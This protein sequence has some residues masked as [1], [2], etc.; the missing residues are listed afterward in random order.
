L[1]VYSRSGKR[2]VSYR[3]SAAWTWVSPPAEAVLGHVRDGLQERERHV[4]PDDGGGL[5]EALVLGRQPVD[6]RRE[7]CLRR[8]RDL[9]R[10]RRLR[11]PIGPPLSDEHLGFHEGL[12][13]LFQEEGVPLGPLDQHPRERLEGPVLAQQ[14]VEQRFGALWWQRVDPQLEVVGLAA[15]GVLV[16]G[17]VVDEEQDAGRRQAL[18]EA[19]E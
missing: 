6:A 17:P 3:N 1:K 10:V 2:L 4:L 19:V 15:P 18:D 14:G 16:L 12:H 13:A 9:P 8:R 11:H 7:D 5:E